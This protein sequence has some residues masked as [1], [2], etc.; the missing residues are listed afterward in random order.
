MQEFV[1]GHAQRPQHLE[2]RRHCVRSR[3]VYYPR[4][5]TMACAHCGRLPPTTNPPCPTSNPPCPTSNPPCPTHPPT[6][7]VPPTQPLCNL[8]ISGPPINAGLIFPTRVRLVLTVILSN[9]LF[10]VAFSRLF[11][12]LAVHFLRIPASILYHTRLPAPL[13]LYL[14]PT[15]PPRRRRLLPP[16]YVAHACHRH[17]FAGT[18]SQ[19]CAPGCRA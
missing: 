8:Y 9:F 7:P 14:S 2:L 15:L 4:L 3:C 17:C 5:P 19:V 6:H 1:V 11:F 13:S 10:T 12:L 18:T 16:C